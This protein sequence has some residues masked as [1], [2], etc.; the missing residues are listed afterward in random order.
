MRKNIASSQGEGFDGQRRKASTCS[1][2]IEPNV[3]EKLQ[4]I[5]DKQGRSLSSL[6]E[7]IL[8]DF[9]DSYEKDNFYVGAIQQD[10]RKHVRKDILL[11]ARW[12]LGK[13]DERFEYDVI[14]KNISTGGAYTVYSNGRS[15]QLVEELQTQPMRLFI[16]LPGSQGPVNLECKAKRIHITESSTTVGI[17]FVNA[18][19]EESFLP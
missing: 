12:R 15:F 10:R 7:L 11:P 5:A 8:N 6:I 4:T 2:R 19:P 18:L 13:E 3:K 17:E 9:L 1:F 14:V 16:K